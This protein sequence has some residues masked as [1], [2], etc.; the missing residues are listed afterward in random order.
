MAMNISSSSYFPHV[1]LYQRLMQKITSIFFSYNSHLMR[2]GYFRTD[3]SASVTCLTNHS[4]SHMTDVAI[5]L[6][7][8][9]IYSTFKERNTFTSI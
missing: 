9:P 1:M 3:S 8:H 5:D 4:K 6:G 7:S 2:A